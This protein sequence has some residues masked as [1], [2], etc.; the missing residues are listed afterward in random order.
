MFGKKRNCP[1]VEN[2]NVF[3]DLKDC[4]RIDSCILLYSNTIDGCKYLNALILQKTGRLSE[5]NKDYEYS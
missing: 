4:E 2:C 1:A 5:E 3:C